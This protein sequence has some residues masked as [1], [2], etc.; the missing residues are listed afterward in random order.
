[1]AVDP[2]PW[3]R[4]ELTD[5]T[6]SKFWEIRQDGRAYEVRYGR[7]GSS[8]R[9]QRKELDSPGACAAMV[10]RKIAEKLE[11]MRP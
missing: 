2:T 6:S 11:P 10:Q 5:D 7:I 4:Y 8:G 1:M 3:L 9:E